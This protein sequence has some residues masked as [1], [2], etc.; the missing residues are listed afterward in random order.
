[1]MS[2]IE[3]QCSFMGF[4]LL[5]VGL[6][7]ALL[8]S[9]QRLFSCADELMHIL[10]LIFYQIYGIMSYAEALTHLKWRFLQGQRWG[11]D[12]TLT[13]IAIQFDQYNVLKIFSP[14]YTVGLSLKLVGCKSVNLYVSSILLHWSMSLFLCYDHA[15]FISIA[16]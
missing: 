10:Y 1:M 8:E 12:F 16:L 5:I 9:V 7:D 13:H 14:M 3:Q 15:V 4:L 6:H 2:C 11:L